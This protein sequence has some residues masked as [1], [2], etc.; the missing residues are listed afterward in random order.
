MTLFQ[1][2]FMLV[3]G[4]G[5][6]AV[7]LQGMNRGWLPN[8]PNGFKKGE[9]VKKEDQPVAFWFFFS[10]YLGGGAAV[11]L[12]ALRLLSGHAAPLPLH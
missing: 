2:L 8:G 12:Y 6:I 9:G 1:G 5:L 10:L 3:L 7:A 4:V 11:A